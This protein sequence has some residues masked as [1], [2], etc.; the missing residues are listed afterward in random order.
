MNGFTEDDEGNH[1]CHDLR[2]DPI[3]VMH[4]YNVTF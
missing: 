3:P 4:L 2:H 1:E